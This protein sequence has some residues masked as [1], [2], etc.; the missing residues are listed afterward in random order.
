MTGAIVAAGLRASGH[1]VPGLAIA[2]ALALVVG[3]VGLLLTA[4]LHRHR[5]LG[6]PGPAGGAIP[7]T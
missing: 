5:T 1:P 6:Q 4:R 2:F 3:L 7:S